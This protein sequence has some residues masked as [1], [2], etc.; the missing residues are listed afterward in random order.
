MVEKYRVKVPKLTEWAERNLPEGFTVFELPERHRIR[1]RTT[2]SLERLNEE[3]K[4][5]TRVARLF[6]NE[7]SL[8]RL[9]CAVVSEIS[10]E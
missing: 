3:I 4:R 5:R 1:L 7:A 2:N 8:I 10:D 6:P 9:V